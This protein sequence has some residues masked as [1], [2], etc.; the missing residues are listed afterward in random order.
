VAHTAPGE[1]AAAIDRFVPYYHRE[2]YHKALGNVA[3]EDVRFSRREALL[4][5]AAWEIA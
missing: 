5:R 3:P 1:L 2:R 4:A